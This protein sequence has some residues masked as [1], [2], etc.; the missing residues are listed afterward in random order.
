MCVYEAKPC[1]FS[2]ARSLNLIF[3]IASSVQNM[4]PR[5][6]IIIYPLSTTVPH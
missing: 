2:H 6:Q 4:S 3:L 1:M 5:W